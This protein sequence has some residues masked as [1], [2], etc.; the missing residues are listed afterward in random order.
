VCIDSIKDVGDD[1]DVL[2]LP[3]IVV[4]ARASTY[5]DVGRRSGEADRVSS[6]LGRVGLIAPRRCRGREDEAPTKGDS[7][8]GG[9]KAALDGV[10]VRGAK[11]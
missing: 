7:S 3:G 4:V 9:R 1:D 6:S 11:P 5:H 8:V 10:G 2:P